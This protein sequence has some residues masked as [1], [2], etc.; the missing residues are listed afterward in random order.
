M[1]AVDA[2]LVREFHFPVR[3]LYRAY[4]HLI[5][6]RAG[7]TLMVPMARISGR[8]DDLMDR[9][10]IPWLEAAAILE[11]DYATAAAPLDVQ[12]LSSLVNGAVDADTSVAGNDVTQL[13]P[14]LGHFAGDNGIACCDRDWRQA[15]FV[16]SAGGTRS[17][18][19]IGRHG[20]RFAF[21]PDFLGD[22]A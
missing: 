20:I 18:V 4:G 3:H 12:R 9:C 8:L 21:T 2:Q 16:L 11:P 15:V 1:K 6:A 14:I 17:R 7:M 19:F 13:M 10:P 5:A 22:V